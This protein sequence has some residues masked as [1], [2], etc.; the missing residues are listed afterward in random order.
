MLIPNAHG[1]TLQ[2]IEA[3]FPGEKH[4]LKPFFG[5]NLAPFCAERM[6]SI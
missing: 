2:R 5:T 6:L 1:H 4:G 3:A